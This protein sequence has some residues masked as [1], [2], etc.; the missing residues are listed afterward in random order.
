MATDTAPAEPARLSLLGMPLEVKRLIYQKY[1]EVNEQASCAFGTPSCIDVNL[2]STNRQIREEALEILPKSNRW[3]AVAHYIASDAAVPLPP[4]DFVPFEVPQRRF[5]KPIIADLLASPTFLF[6]ARLGH[7]C[8][9]SR[10]LRARRIRHSIFAFN[11]STSFALCASWAAN[12]PQWPNFSFDITPR[13]HNEVADLLPDFI[14]YI[15]M[16]RNASAVDFTQLTHPILN[17]IA[18]TIIKPTG[19]P[20]RW[21][22]LLYGLKEEGNHAYTEDRLD[23]ASY[24][25]LSPDNL[26]YA[27][28]KTSDSK[29]G[30]EREMFADEVEV[31]SRRFVRRA[32]YEWRYVWEIDPIDTDAQT[33]LDGIRL[34]FRYVDRQFDEAELVPKIAKIN[35]AGL[36]VWRGDLRMARRFLLDKGYPLQRT[37]DQDFH[38]RTSQQMMQ[39][40]NTLGITHDRWAFKAFGQLRFLVA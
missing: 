36:G 12:V 29:S 20:E 2:L 17:H 3:I 13:Y 39:F 11:R 15:A 6:T 38:T 25:I 34:W 35:I 5:S 26:E 10:P 22:E 31:L 18:R 21:H 4:T 37:A 9:V 40:K 32:A 8:D 24:Y 28:R 23:D 27:K 19:R 30:D 33:K 16:I 7:G 14:L 1:F